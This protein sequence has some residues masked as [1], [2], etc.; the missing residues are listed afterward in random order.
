MTDRAPGAGR[1]VDNRA[2]PSSPPYGPDMEIRLTV[3]APRRRARAEAVVV[4]WSGAATVRDL[5]EALGAHLVAPVAHLSVGGSV[6]G[7]EHRIGVPPL[8]DGA[9]VTVGRAGAEDGGA[10]AAA[11][12]PPAV[13]VLAAVGGPDAGRSLPLRPPGVVVGR[14]PATG[15]RLD[16][17]AL[18][19]VHCRFHVD[20]HG[21]AVEDLGSTNGVLVDGRPVTTRTPVD[22]RSTVAI[23][24]TTLRLRRAGPPGASVHH[25]GDGTVRVT[26]P[27]PVEAPLPQPSLV[28]P[29][30]P[31][32]PARGRVPWLAALAPLPVVA[33]LALVLGPQV[34]AF[35]VL[36]P[37]VL[38]ATG[39]GD[40]AGS[41]RRHRRAL[42]LH[43]RRLAD[44]ER[45]VAAAL[46]EE[47][48]LR[49]LRHPDPHEVLERAEQ[50]GPGLW[51]H[52]RDLTVR[53]G[54]GPVD[55]AAVVTD[56]DGQRR[57]P[58]LAGAPVVVDLDAVGVLGVCG[59]GPATAALLS[60]VVGQLAVR[61]PPSSV[62]LDVARP[63][64]REGEWEWAA[65]LPHRSSGGRPVLV[66]PDASS[67]GAAARLSRALVAGG[68]AVVAAD[69]AA[70]AH[71]GHRH[72]GHPRLR[73]SP[74]RRRA[75][76]GRRRRRAGVARAPG[77]RARTAPRGVTRGL[78]TASSR[79][80]PG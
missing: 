45:V 14:S 33:V 17:P 58:L 29:R 79:G 1:P 60:A 66:V 18:S 47:V 8:L 30:S 68:V 12:H 38:L 46:E 76:G 78:R 55:A 32:P 35:A 80:A 42:G 63:P 48:R 43:A 39:L 9:S 44:H 37:V 41:R 40:R 36:G 7:D 71:P 52:G 15:L 31:D 6:L 64:G 50:R 67:P 74:R 75:T 11:A 53:L 34:L 72:R 51:G 69:D 25:P 65:L 13:L 23:G 56:A 62:S 54:T 4:R 49:L 2:G 59:P 10:G 3:H 77:S 16:D 19:R 70:V 28:A 21:A 61:C 73:G 57:P 20:E 5:R 24:A 26:P 22:A 27:P